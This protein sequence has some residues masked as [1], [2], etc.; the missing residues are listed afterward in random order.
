MVD[1]LIVGR[2][3]HTGRMGPAL[4][5]QRLDAGTRKRDRRGQPGGPGADERPRV[6][7]ISDCICMRVLSSDVLSCER[8]TIHFIRRS[9]QSNVYDCSAMAT[10]RYEQRERAEAAERTRR[11]I[12]DAV[13]ERLRDVARRSRYR[14]RGSRRVAGSPARPSTRSSA[15]AAGCSTR[16]PPTC[17]RG[18]TTS[19]YSR[20]STSEDAREHMRV[21]FRSGTDMLAADRDIVRALFSMAQLDPSELSATRSGKREES[22]R[23]RHERALP[24]ASREQKLLAPGVSAADR[25][26]TPC[27]CSRASRAFDLLHT[28]RGLSARRGRRPR[29]P[30]RPS[31]RC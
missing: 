21:G 1:V 12:L 14:S 18:T 10:R 3:R 28:G 22:P 16:W 25:P 15:R 7:L 24:I 8:R 6:S 5:E 23:G 4:Q 11:R 31:A 17:W 30:K 9:V 19:D 13:I 20:R 27:G 2:P 29:S 26:S